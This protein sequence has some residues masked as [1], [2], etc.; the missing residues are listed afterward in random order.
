MNEFEESDGDKPGEKAE[1]VNKWCWD[2]KLASERNYK[3]LYPFFHQRKFRKLNLIRGELSA[4]TH[5]MLQS[6]GKESVM[7]TVQEQFRIGRR[8]AGEG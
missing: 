1:L 7:E 6:K 8:Q 5:G 2:N 4:E 3:L